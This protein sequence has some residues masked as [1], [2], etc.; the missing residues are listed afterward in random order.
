[1]STVLASAIVSFIVSFSMMKVS[2]HWFK[3]WIDDFFIKE[4]KFI[5]AQMEDL[6][7][8]FKQSFLR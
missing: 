5:K 4:D 6:M 2:F 3:R 7:E 8:R 1:M